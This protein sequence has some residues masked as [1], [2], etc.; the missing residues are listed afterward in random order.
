MAEWYGG[1]TRILEYGRIEESRAWI[2][3]GPEG[4]L[5]RFGRPNLIT[6]EGDVLPSER[7][8]MGEDGIT[9]DLALRAAD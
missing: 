9:D 4:I 3:K 8:D 6:V 7:S 2:A 5:E 1:Q